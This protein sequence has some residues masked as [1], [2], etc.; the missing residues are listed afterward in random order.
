MQKITPY[1]WFNDQLE[2]AIHFYISIFD[3]SRLIQLN[4]YESADPA[5]PSIVEASF[6]LEGQTFY[7]LNGGPMFSF[8]PAISFFVS[9]RNEQEVTDLWDKLSVQGTVL[10]E[11]GTY[12]FSEKYGWLND[13]FGVSWQIGVWNKK[14]RI[15]PFLMFSGKQ[16]GKVSDA[17]RLYTSVFKDSQIIN[18]EETEFS[19]NGL[20]FMTLDSDIEHAFTFSPA[21]SFYVSCDNQA[22]IDLLWEKLSEGGK[23]QMCGWLEDQFGVSW[24]IE[25]VILEKYMQD[26]DP[27]K[28]KKVMEAMLKM[29]K[30]DIEKLE[31]AYRS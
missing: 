23:K 21:T 19:I 5:N 22:E 18:K 26:K 28:A 1:L 24:Q 7:G 10:M 17:I 16:H 14:Q 29:S 15:T 2:K 8:T 25:P 9:C 11:L 4:K 31:Q 13:Q 27:V 30:M 12:P 3:N 20:E 6:Q